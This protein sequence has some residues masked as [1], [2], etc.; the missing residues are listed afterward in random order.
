VNGSRTVHLSGN[1]VI[2]P[3]QLGSDDDDSEEDEDDL[4]ED[5]GGL[6]EVATSESEEEIDELDNL[7]APRLTEVEED[8]EA[9]TLIK[10]TKKKGKRVA[11][12]LDD[13]EVDAALDDLIGASKQESKKEGKKEGKKD[14]HPSKKL[15]NNE[16]QAITG[17]DA[18]VANGSTKKDDTKA[19][20]PKPTKSTGKNEKK[21]SPANGSAKKVQFAEKLEQGPTPSANVN[22]SL[23]KKVVKGVNI[24]DRKAGNGPTAKK[25]DKIAM[26]YI[27][28]LKD[29]KVFDCKFA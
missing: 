13:D 5:D 20:E 7:A 4:L 10:V 21:D 11:L 3:E 22:G 1:F 9:P 26:R 18:T 24:D 2:D 23:G 29:G 16:G 14:K 17:S 27:G 25:G 8:E 19:K 28:K 12:E 15:K 6:Y